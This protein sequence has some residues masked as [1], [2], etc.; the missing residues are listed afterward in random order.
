MRQALA[1]MLVVCMVALSATGDRVRL[2]DGRVIEGKARRSE[3]KVFIE[4][5][6]GVVSFPASE[7][8]SIEHTPTPAEVVEWRL[9]QIERT[10]PDA[11]FEIAQWAADNDPRV[12]RVGRFLR[13]TRLDELPQLYNIWRGEM[14]FVGVRPIRQHF[15]TMLAEQA[16]LY[17][18][19]FLAKPGLTGWDQVHNGYPS[20]LEAQLR[21]FSFDLYYLKNASFW[22]D[23]LVLGKTV[24]VILRC[25]GH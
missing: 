24:K 12:T 9:T 18:V 20:T 16:P 17:Q 4:L 25:K 14:S 7:V 6:Y 10:D 1:A 2:K 23:L 21:K 5:N 19:R 11:L 22:L 13:K 3:G 15:A 8:V